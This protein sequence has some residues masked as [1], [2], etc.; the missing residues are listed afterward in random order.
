[1]PL[2]QRRADPKPKDGFLELPRSD[3]ELRYGSKI[4]RAIR[5]YE[6]RKDMA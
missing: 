4:L 2:C 6:E 3:I 5:N 1:M